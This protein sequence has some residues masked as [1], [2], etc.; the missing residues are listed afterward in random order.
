MRCE[1]GYQTSCVRREAVGAGGAQA[2]LLRC[3]WPTARS[4][5]RRTSLRRTSSRASSPPDVLGTGWF[6]AV[7]ADVRPGKTVV[8][9]G[10]GAVGLLQVLA[11]KQLG[12]ERIVA[13]SRHQDRQKLALDYGAT[14]IVEERGDDGVAR[15]S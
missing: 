7:A 4:W 3:R 15:M 14:E 6:G 1:A 12:A 13:M 5:P 9:V 10:D 2:E 8:V 11:A